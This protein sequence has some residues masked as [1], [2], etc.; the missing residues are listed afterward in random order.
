MQNMAANMAK[1][2]D[3][4][5]VF[6]L[7]MDKESIDDRWMA[8]ESGVN[9][10]KLI[11]G[12]NDSDWQR[13]MRVAEKKASWPILVDD[14]GNLPVYELKRRGRKMVQMGARILFIDQASK[15]K[16]DH[17]KTIF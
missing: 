7:E 14:S 17:R 9:S 12:M 10:L 16:G 3:M 1:N 5:G 8:S 15:L 6:S 2:G 11:N 13:V 4:V